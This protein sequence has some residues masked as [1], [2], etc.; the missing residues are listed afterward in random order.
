M[1]KLIISASMRLY[2]AIADRKMAQ[3]FLTELGFKGLR[4]KSERQDE[5]KFFYT[6]YDKALVTKFLGKPKSADKS[7]RY[8]FGDQGVVAI[9]ESTDTVILKNSKRGS[10]RIHTPVNKPVPAPEVPTAPPEPRTGTENDDAGVPIVHISPELHAHYQMAQRDKGYRLRFMAELWRYLNQTKFHGSLHIP[11]IRLMKTVK[12]TSFRLRGFWRAGN[13]EFAISPRLFNASQAFFV[14]VFLHEMAHQAVSEIDR[15]YSREA[16]GHGP[17]WQRWMVK[18]GLNPRRFDPNENTTYMNRQEKQEVEDRR[19]RIAESLKGLVP[20]Q[21]TNGPEVVTVIWNGD[22]YQGIAICP[23]VASGVK[24]AFLSFEDIEAYKSGHLQW[25]IV[26]KQSIFQ[27]TM[28][29]KHVD[30][31]KAKRLVTIIAN[32]YE[33]KTLIRKNKARERKYGWWS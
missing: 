15:V 9:W 14:E 11:N 16:Q 7:I 30:Q 32:H 12:G 1:D 21:I 2:A 22:R 13:R 19:A 26:G 6:D 18:I 27:P 8:N 25:K 4:F 23:T 17:E 20:K 29:T 5:I 24:W 3:V 10:G 33:T 31:E 28:Y